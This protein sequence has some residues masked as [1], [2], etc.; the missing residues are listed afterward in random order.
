MSFLLIT[1]CVNTI[2]VSGQYNLYNSDDDGFKPIRPST[3]RPEIATQ[4][5][6]E[7]YDDDLDYT[8][9]PT[10]ATTTTTTTTTYRPPKPQRLISTRRNSFRSASFEKKKNI[11]TPYVDSFTEASNE[12]EI[13]QHPGKTKPLFLPQLRNTILDVDRRVNG[14]DYNF[15]SDKSS[16]TS[17]ESNGNF[18]RRYARFLF[19]QR[20]G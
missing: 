15:A 9:A 18:S 14:K 11:E 6:Y 3:D 13:V 17:A 12:F 4:P 1:L 7:Y 8:Q 19:K 20:T 16:S 2:Y 10:I 5:E